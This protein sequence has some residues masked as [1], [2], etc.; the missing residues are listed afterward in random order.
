MQAFTTTSFG[1]GK[2]RNLSPHRDDKININ[3]KRF[4]LF[5]LTVA[6][7]LYLIIGAL[8]FSSLE[9]SGYKKRREQ[10]KL[11]GRDWLG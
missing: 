4:M 11:E 3:K 8:I 9:Y 2:Q 1:D 10:A 5:A 6:Y 7:F